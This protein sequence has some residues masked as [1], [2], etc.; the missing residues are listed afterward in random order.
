MLPKYRVG[1]D[2]DVERANRE[3]NHTGTM[4]GVATRTPRNRGSLP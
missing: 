3:S 4:D 1:A 2:K